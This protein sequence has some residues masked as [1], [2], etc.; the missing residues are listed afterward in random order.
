[1]RERLLDAIATP[2]PGP[3]D[4]AAAQSD[5]RGRDAVRRP[6]SALGTRSFTIRV[7]IRCRS[8]RRWRRSA[9]SAA[10]RTPGSAAAPGNW[11]G[12]ASEFS[13]RRAVW[14]RSNGTRV[15]IDATGAVELVTGVPRSARVSPPPWRRSAPTR[16]GSTTGGCGSCWDRPTVSNYGIG[17]H[18]SRALV[19]TG[20]ATH[21]A[22]LRLRAK[23]LEMAASLLQDGTR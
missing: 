1:V 11:S 13:S 8:I 17:A 22:S 18:A 6:L 14:V 23:A 10:S 7:T 12:P 21:A 16:W 15:S 20:S 19:M 3:G 9:G 5:H 4:R 2:R